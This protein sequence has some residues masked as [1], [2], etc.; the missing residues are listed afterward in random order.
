M[1]R[2]PKHETT[3]IT[4][5]V[6]GTP[7][8]VTLFPPNGRLSSWYVYWPGLPNSRS[9]GAKDMQDAI[10]AAESMV[11]NGGNRPTLDVVAMS[12]EEFEAIQ[13]HH[14]SRKRAPDSL[15]RAAK[16]LEVC[17]EAADAFRRIIGV[18]PISLATPDDCARFQRLALELPKSW[19][20][21]YPKARK[22]GV[23]NIS[24]NTILKW[25]RS[26][27]AAFER[28][29]ISAGRKCVRGVVPEAKLL[30]S[31]PWRQ[32]QWIEG[33]T[34]EKRQLSEEELL[35]ILDYFEGEWPNVKAALTAVK[36]CLWSWARLSEMTNLKWDDLRTVGREQHFQ[37]IGKWGV[38]K[39]ARL[40]TGLMEELR[41]I[42]VGSTYVFASYNRQL[43]K[44]YCT[45]GRVRSAELVSD[46]FSPKAF[47]DWFQERI[48]DWATQTGH[49][50]ATPH[51][52]RK[53]ALQ[54]ARTG[55]D[56]NR[57]VAHDARLSESVMMAHYVI[58]RDEEM[59]QS[60]NRTYHRILLS[61][62]LEV[63][64]RYGYRPDDETADLEKRLAN[65]TAAKDW[66]TVGKLASQ[67]THRN[68]QA[69]DAAT[70][71]KADL[72]SP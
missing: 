34:K 57:Q 9:T 51:A 18:S 5:V 23:S 41:A 31:N 47:G 70:T 43:R 10:V 58:E 66:E 71:E 54:H 17:L 48:Q 45:A 69:S 4:V 53:T 29:N 16:S 32:F 11:R 27:A 59:R 2:K 60:S 19:R 13:R 64:T 33:T 7:V 49:A 6:D 46:E 62:S 36:T 52:F 61:L 3:K 37:I 38:E 65:A 35:S 72:P 25:T 42:K 28:A 8:P 26:L 12:D 40:P 44:F 63:A 56:L 39:W 24:P 67:L 21:Q 15:R 20:L 55:E 14:F 30:K 1:P 22:I 68:G 50:P